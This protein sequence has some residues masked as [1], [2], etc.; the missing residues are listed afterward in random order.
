[1]LLCQLTAPAQSLTP[2][3]LKPIVFEQKLNSAVRLS[4]PFRD[5][6]GRPVALSNYFG[7]KP[8]IL[9][10]GYY[11]CPMLCTL[12]LNGM[13][14]SLQDMKWSI[15]REFEVVS[16]SIDPQEHS[17]L[18][19]AKKKTYLKRY[20]RNGGDAGWHFLTG[21]KAAIAE[22]ADAVG[23]RYAY[24]PVVR[25]YA[26]P[27]GLV[28][29]TPQGRVSKYLFGVKFA[30]QEI[31]AGLKG[32][33]QN[34]IGSRIQQLVLLCFHYSP[35]QG[36]YG[37]AIMTTLRVLGAATLVGLVWLWVRLVRAR[38]TETPAG[39]NPPQRID[40]QKQLTPRP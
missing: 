1:M 30:P 26:H 28:I 8:V 7:A 29:L 21:D 35:I 36:K 19:A 4:L 13:I 33:S 12:T 14:E 23:F 31:L 2:A 5:E 9:V 10:L 6:A 17:T 27:A 38:P 40:A 16:V 25:Q 37:P 39:F 3:D 34:S 22:L 15:G 24:D 32:A 20:G 11:G 18:A